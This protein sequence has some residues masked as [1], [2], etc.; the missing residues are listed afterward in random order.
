MKFNRRELMQDNY[1]DRHTY[2]ITTVS[3]AR[4]GYPFTVERSTPVPMVAPR[5]RG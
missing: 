4:A 1:E 5:E 3:P 2:E